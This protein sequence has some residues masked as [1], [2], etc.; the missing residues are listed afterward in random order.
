MIRGTG[1][2]RTSSRLARSFPEP[3]PPAKARPSRVHAVA[4]WT[5]GVDRALAA[6]LQCHDGGAPRRLP[7][8]APGDRSLMPQPSVQAANVGE[9]PCFLPATVLRERIAR[10]ELSPVEVTR[11]VL[12]RAEARGDE[13]S[14]D[15][16][17]G[18]EAT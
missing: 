5:G 4:E 2:S 7:L 14:R 9:E 16:R 13:L 15:A 10:R 1:T 18:A 3:S 8:A 6:T 11:A 17:I 12:K